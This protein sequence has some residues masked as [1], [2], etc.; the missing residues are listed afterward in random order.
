MLGIVFGI[1]FD[2]GKDFEGFE[3]MISIFN[4]NFI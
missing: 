1:L 4:R 3:E 2:L